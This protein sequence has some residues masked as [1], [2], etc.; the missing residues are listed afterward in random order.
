[1]IHQDNERNVLST[2]N[3]DGGNIGHAETQ[4]PALTEASFF[5][6]SLYYPRAL[7]CFR[8]SEI[9]AAVV[10]QLNEFMDWGDMTHRSYRREH[11]VP[12]SGP[13]ENYLVRIASRVDL[14]FNKWMTIKRDF[15]SIM[16]KHRTD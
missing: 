12:S 1:M 10:R 8:W 14:S 16:S 15:I 11:T 7:M 13:T 6:V 9:Y 5:V 4:F 2:F 3:D